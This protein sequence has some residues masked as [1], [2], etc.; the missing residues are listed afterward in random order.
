[1]D[2]AFLGETVRLDWKMIAINTTDKISEQY[3]FLDSCN[4]V[5]NE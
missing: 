3:Q 2:K 1:M 5:F 4:K